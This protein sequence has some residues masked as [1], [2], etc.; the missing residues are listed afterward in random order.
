MVNKYFLQLYTRA[1]D[2]NLVRIWTVLYLC[3]L[4][5]FQN[6]FF[7]NCSRF[8]VFWVARYAMFPDVSWHSTDFKTHLTFIRTSSLLY[9][10]RTK[11]TRIIC[12]HCRWY[13]LLP[14]P[15]PDKRHWSARSTVCSYYRSEAN[16]FPDSISGPQDRLSVPVICLNCRWYGLLPTPFPIASLVRTIDCLF[17][18]AVLIVGGTAYCQPLPIIRTNCRWYG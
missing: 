2:R 15:S 1:T 17:R 18:L 12:P 9:D 11:P 7:T 8:C 14:T 13:G 3:I 6:H 4:R 10:R 5:S 16:P